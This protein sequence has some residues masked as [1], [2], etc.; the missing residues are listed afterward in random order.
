MTDIS[1]TK[2]I[3]LFEFPKGEDVPGNQELAETMEN[4]AGSCASSAELSKS[5]A[6]RLAMLA[7]E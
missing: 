5:E 4:K 2:L 3:K 7:T 6:Y 1:D